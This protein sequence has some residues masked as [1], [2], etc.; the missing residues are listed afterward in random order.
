MRTLEQQWRYAK[1]ALVGVVMGFVGS[2]VLLA[3]PA[4]ANGDHHPHPSTSVSHSASASASVSA[5][6]SASATVPATPTATVTATT[7]ATVTP[8]ETPLPVSDQLPVTGPSVW[9][10]VG[11][12]VLALLFGAGVARL[13]RGRKR[14]FRAP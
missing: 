1:A 5:S 12:G 10:I 8:S 13:A 2:L 3:A 9:T 7:T 4:Q 11:V 6:A 14:T